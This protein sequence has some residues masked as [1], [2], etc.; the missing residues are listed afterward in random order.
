MLR[1]KTIV[2][3]L[4]ALLFFAACDAEDDTPAST[5]DPGAELED[6]GEELDD[7]GEE[8]GEAIEE[9]GQAADADVEETTQDV[10]E[11]IEETT[12]D[13]E[14][15]AEETTQDVEEGVEEADENIEETTQDIEESAEEVGEDVD[16]IEGPD[17]GGAIE[18]AADEAEEATD[19]LEEETDELDDADDRITIHL[20]TPAD[21]ELDTEAI[22]EQL[23]DATDLMLNVVTT[24]DYDEALEELCD[25]EAQVALLDATGYVIAQENDCIQSG[26]SGVRSQTTT[27]SLMVV[28]ADADDETRFAG[29]V[30]RTPAVANTNWRVVQAVW[31]DANADLDDMDIIDVA[32]NEAALDNLEDDTCRTA[33]LTTNGFPQHIITEIEPFPNPIFAMADDLT[34]SE[35]SALGDALT[36]LAENEQLPWDTLRPVAADTL[37]AFTNQLENFAVNRELEE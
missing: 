12:Q 36:E 13:V 25:D 20:V 8:L 27:T 32:T 9:A 15:G 28:A 35:A 22:T 30:C 37:R 7:T 18:E 14:E 19:E 5:P 33:I 26:Y 1:F 29:P 23:M 24:D 34:E 6:A 31:A 3:L 17:V 10:E 11:D 2:L 16:D 21:E 4:M